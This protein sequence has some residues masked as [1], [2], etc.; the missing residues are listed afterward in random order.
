MR[1][2][3]DAEYRAKRYPQAIDDLSRAIA[4]GADDGL[5]WL[6][7]AQALAGAQD[8]HLQ[9]SAYN[10]YVKSSDPVDRG[11]A[12]FLIGGDFD[13]H[14]KQK[15]ALAAF[16]AGLALTPSAVVAERVDQ[17]RRLVAF[18]VTKVEIAAEA[19]SPRACLRFNETI[20]TGADISYGDFVH[21]TPELAGIVTARGDTLCLDGLKHGETYEVELL[22][23]FPAATGEKTLESW[24]GRI[25]VPD[26]KPAIS[27]SGTG[28]VL[29]RE[30][31]AGLPVTTVNLDK[32]K[33]RLVRI[34]ERNLVPSIDADK[35]TMSFDPDSVD[36]LINQSGSLVWQG[37]MSIA[38]ERNRAVATAIPLGDILRDKGPGVY[39]AVVERA[40]AKPG[41]DSQPATNW[42]L[43]S[44]LG[45]TTYTG[46]D[47]MA[48]AVR[49]L[50]DAKPLAGVALRLYARNNGELASVTSDADGIGHIPGGL[51]HGK[52][53]DEPFAVM[54]YGP[55]RTGDFNFLE[56]GRAAF[57]LSDRGVSGSAAAGSG[58]RLSL[59]RSRH[60]PP[61]RGGPSDRAGARRQGRG[62]RRSAA[63]LAAVAAGRGRG[64]SPPAD[65]RQARR[66]STRPTRWRAMRASAPG[67]SS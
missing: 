47:G 5:I 60:L 66:P 23:G 51:L 13:R 67:G 59:Y 27:F 64:R 18:R 33:V 43:V 24:K 48:V 28:Y 15:E 49:S 2:D 35:L 31:S 3:A 54:A 16:E 19:D 36:E 9:A 37:E 41:D 46:S 38:G 25:V 32:V 11:T 58:R 6:R 57:D 17:L 63:D 45:L 12:L 61:G 22:A 26:R 62:D 39:L 42:V 10:A 4:Y 20:A 56:V 29:P 52:G 14:D 34:N 53:G 40:D 30:G 44:N 50:A 7:L 8:D 55:A 1:R 21:A 65:R